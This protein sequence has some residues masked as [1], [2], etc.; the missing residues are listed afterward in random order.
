MLVECARYTARLDIE[1][2]GAGPE[3]PG[4]AHESG[5]RIDLSRGA[6]GD[7]QIGRGESQGDAVHQ[8]GHL[9]EPDDIWSQNT[10]SAAPQALKF[11]SDVLLP[12]LDGA[13]VEAAD[14]EQFAMHVQ[15][16][17]ASSSLMQV[18]DI[19]GDERDRAVAPVLLKLRDGSVCCIGHYRPECSTTQIV[20][21]L[22]QCW[23]ACESLGRGDI[24]HP[25]AFPKTV[26]T[27]KRGEA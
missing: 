26:S 9:S 11:R 20:K 24:F 8:V 3:L 2:H 12:A 5:R 10:N 4:L 18:I 16:R 7:K 14:F 22:N 15:N 1:L 6:D 21:M 19:L 25:M 13:A 23:I 27:T 17:W